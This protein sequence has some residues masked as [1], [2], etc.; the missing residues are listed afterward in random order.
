MTIRACSGNVFVRSA[1][2]FGVAARALLGFRQKCGLVGVM[3]LRTSAVALG[4]C[5][6]LLAVTIHAGGASRVNCM[7]I[8]SVAVGA[9]SVV[10]RLFCLGCVTAHTFGCSARQEIVRFVT[11]CARNS[12]F[13]MRVVVLADVLM[14][15]RAR[16]DAG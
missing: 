12:P 11:R 16:S 2:F 14:A 4:K 8:T 9:S 7:R 1:R 15:A 13:E 5:R 10:G 6:A 3:A